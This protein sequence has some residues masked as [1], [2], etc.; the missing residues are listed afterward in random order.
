MCVKQWLLLPTLFLTGSEA[1]AKFAW[2]ISLQ[3]YFIE[4]SESLQASDPFMNWAAFHTTSKSM[5]KMLVVLLK[6]TKLVKLDFKHGW[7]DRWDEQN[8]ESAFE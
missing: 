7:T 1:F 8:P 6:M 4:R 2:Q 5:L 3:I